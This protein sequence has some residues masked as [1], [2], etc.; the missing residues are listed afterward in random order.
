M[1]A[2]VR[3]I[4]LTLVASQEMPRVRLASMPEA[5]QAET[6]LALQA[7]MAAGE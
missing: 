3:S 5:S 2:L 7:G 1:L 6:H 4:G